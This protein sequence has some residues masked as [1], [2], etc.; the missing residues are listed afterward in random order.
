PG[1]VTVTP[2]SRVVDA[3]ALAG[4]PLADA[5]I[6]RVNLARVVNDGEQITVP[7][8]GDVMPASGVGALPGAGGESIGAPVDLN[9]ADLAALDSLPGVG[10]VLGQ[11]ILDWRSAHGRFTSV[12]ELGE[13]S[14]IGQKLLEQVRPKVRV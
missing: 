5:D 3:I 1:V 11:R 12:D 13:V 4:G 8:P 14:G 6:Q 10:P 2:G 9:R 7:R